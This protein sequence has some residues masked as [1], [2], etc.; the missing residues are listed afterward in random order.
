MII[1]KNARL[2]NELTEGYNNKFADLLIEGNKIK[3]IEECGFDFN[4]NDAKIIDANGKTLMP[5]LWDLHAHLYLQSFTCNT[6]LI[7][8]DLGEELFDCY[9]YSNE[10]L[11]QGYTTIRDVGATMDTAIFLR[12]AINRGDLKG[13]RIIAAGIIITPTETG[14]KT[15][16][17][18]YAE[19]DSPD[20]L[21]K[22]AR[23]ELQK[24]ADFLKYMG[25]GA[26][27]NDG[28]VMGQRIATVKELETIQEIANLKNT[29]V[30]VHC[31]G[32]E[33]IE[34]CIEVGI[35]TIEHAT[36][37]SDKAIE[38]L[39]NNS[40]TFLIP[41]LS[42]VALMLKERE[43]GLSK[44]VNDEKAELI[45][46]G[47]KC[48]KKAYEAGLKL[49][50]GTDI[51]MTGFIEHP[52]LE[53]IVRKEYLGISNIDMLLQATKNSAEIAGY[54]EELGTIKVG[55]I[56]DLII[57]D[58]NPDEDIKVMCKQPLHVIRDGEKLL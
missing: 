15:F 8:K 18:L 55:K 43:K 20:E 44:N 45:Y 25:T 14:N 53:F 41:T 46:Y 28:G 36:M 10:Y 23:Q 50:W 6:E 21:R 58:G 7:L 48:L 5:G 1:I 27:T 29:Y 52:G 37:V 17:K 49:G 56:A 30:A 51:P 26:G 24:G 3:H 35:R 11:K 38:M 39:K 22:V 33:G 34:K 47:F 2:I 54:G 31:H 16:P 19:V 57:V 9:K 40:K 13:I 32:S 4:I 42:I 12:N